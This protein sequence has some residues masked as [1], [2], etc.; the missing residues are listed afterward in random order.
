MEG[1]SRTLRISAAKR[2]EHEIKQGE[3]GVISKQV[4]ALAQITP[5]CTLA[6]TSPETFEASRE[7]LRTEP[8][9]VICN[10]PGHFDSY[11]VL[12]QIDRDDIKIV[13][14]ERN[15]KDV[16]SQFG[17]VPLIKATSDRSEGRQFFA[18]ISEHI[19]SGGL[20]LF[21]PTGGIDH[22]GNK[23]ASI[24][25]QRG[26]GGILKYCLRPTDMVYSFYVEPGN[27]RLAATGTPGR[28][29]TAAS[30]IAVPHVEMIRALTTPVTIATHERYATAREW[31]SIAKE[32]NGLTREECLAKHFL[33]QFTER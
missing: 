6:E 31:Q 23:D 28:L 8:G 11:I 3:F 2:F 1:F 30:A 17:D 18:S 9:L 4:L 7:R 15:Y 32:S 21:Y 14:S 27:V 16:E 20:V 26:F 19:Q 33:S 13:V 12:S 22:I 25:F 29:S 24:E 5:V 10:H